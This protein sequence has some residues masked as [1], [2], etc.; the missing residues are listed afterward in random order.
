VKK[1]NNSSINTVMT[2]ALWIMLA[3]SFIFSG[4][5]YKSVSR[6]EMKVQ[7]YEKIIIE[8]IIL[9]KK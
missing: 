2:L 4:L 1:E 9:N 5:V 3:G 6:M 8:K 7:Q